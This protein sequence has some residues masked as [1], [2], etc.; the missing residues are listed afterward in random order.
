MLFVLITRALLTCFWTSKYF[1]NSVD[2]YAKKYSFLSLLSRRN[3]YFAH[4]IDSVELGFS[5]FSIFECFLLKSS[6]NFELFSYCRS[7]SASGPVDRSILWKTGQ[8]MKQSDWLKA[9]ESA[10]EKLDEKSK[11]LYISRI[12]LV[13]YCKC[14][15]L[16]GYSTRYLLFNR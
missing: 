10:P 14:Y 1:C 8:Q 15:N 6:F 9:I 11:L 7:Q 13:Y 16:I 4:E 3:V 5:S 12:I 2:V